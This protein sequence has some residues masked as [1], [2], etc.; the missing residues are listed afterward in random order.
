MR[1]PTA[2]AR[3]GMITTP[4]HLATAAGQRVLAA[5]GN[6]IEAAIA[7]GAVLTVVYPH[8]NSIGGDAFFGIDDGKGYVSGLDGAGSAGA[9]CSIDKYRALGFDAIPKRGPPSA[10]TVAGMVS[11]WGE[12]FEQ[13]RQ[14]GGTFSWADLL[15]PAIALAED[16]FA[17]NAG[18]PSSLHAHWDILSKTQ[19]FVDTF[20]PEGVIPLPGSHFKQIA[21]AN[22]LHQLAQDGAESFYRG[23]LGQRIGNGLHAEGSLLD[24]ADLAAF[25]CK[26]V[27]LLQ[28]P[29]R[30]GQVVN[31][32]P[33]TVGMT[34]LMVLAIL[35]RFD[36]TGLDPQSA[37]FVHLQVEAAKLAHQLRDQYLNDPDFN[38]VPTAKLL[39]SAF[40]DRLAASIDPDRAAPFTNGPTPGD[41]VWFGVMDAE[42]RA[43]SAIQSICWEYGSGVMAGDT[44]ILWH[45]RG[46]GFSMDP[47]HVN[48][49]APGKRPSHTL[50]APLFL[51]DGKTRIVF[52]TM[53]GEAQPQIST[54]VLTRALDLGMPLDEALD[55]PR[56]VIGRAWGDQSPTSLKLERRFSQ[57]TYD[58]LAAMGHEME[59]FPGDYSDFVGHAGIIV[60]CDDA[61]MQGCA[62]PRSD[63]AALGVDS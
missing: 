30:D 61:N 35:D 7:A 19:R 3:Q 39:D 40:I 52:G 49:L 29:Y 36:L 62:D 32:P 63:G 45:N 51:K 60:L 25:R 15:A 55:A 43:V 1:S 22:T 46:H 24:A 17:L 27:D 53:G 31:L 12:A 5:G 33:P 42:H 44:G 21:L 38:P 10:T 8:M 16:G 58:E 13:S 23:A 9:A 20:A 28:V 14:W 4:H 41:T 50:N 37:R 2:T 6:A 59:W 57:Q 11:V 26:R 56:W 48:A 47:Q 54:A 34:A 18:Q